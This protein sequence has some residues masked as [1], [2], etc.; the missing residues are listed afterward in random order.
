MRTFNLF[1]SDDEVI[2]IGQGFC[3]RTLPKEKFNHAGHFAATLWLL[4]CRDDLD[5]AR[6]MP[7]L[8]R[9][10]NVAVGGANTDTAGYH[11]TITQA[12]I[13]AAR[14]FMAQRSDWRLFRVCNALLESPLGDP[15]WLLTHWSRERLF[16]VAA[17]KHWTEPD[18]APL[19]F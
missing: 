17:R 16:S 9:A 3:D 13:R 10:Y 19:P 14:G 6:D 7:A 8:I 4:A 11:E 15:E 18:L 5:A 1:V 2:A 12:S